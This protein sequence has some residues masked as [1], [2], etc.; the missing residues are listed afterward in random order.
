MKNAKRVDRFLHGIGLD[1]KKLRIVYRFRGRRYYIPTFNA[2][3]WILNGLG[4]VAS[5]GVVYVWLVGLV[6]L[7]K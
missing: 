5:Y 2:L 3:W 6:T 7:L 4:C 1:R